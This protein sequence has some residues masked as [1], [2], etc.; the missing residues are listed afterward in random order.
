[1][2][3][4]KLYGVHFAY[5]SFNIFTIINKFH[6]VCI[7]S[8]EL[9]QAAMN[10]KYLCEQLKRS[11]KKENVFTNVWI[12]RKAIQQVFKASLELT[13]ISWNDIRPNVIINCVEHD[14]IE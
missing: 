14:A 2:R 8:I 4:S 3:H 9:E 10:S 5:V 6:S 7:D 12:G 13:V 11:K 1:M